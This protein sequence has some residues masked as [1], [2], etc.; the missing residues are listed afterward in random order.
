MSSL[1]DYSGTPAV[2]VFTLHDLMH[3]LTLR[4]MNNA[5]PRAQMLI[6]RAIQDTIRQLPALHDWNYYKRQ[7]RFTSTAGF[8][9]E[10][11]YDHDGATPRLLTITDEDNIWPTD[12]SYGEIWYGGRPYR[13]YRR[14][15]STQVMLEEA[16]S[17]STD[18]EGSVRFERRAYQFSREITKVHHM[19]NLTTNRWIEFMPT[20]E[21]QARSHARWGYGLT[22]HFTFQNHGGL[23]GSTEIILLPSS[24]RAETYEVTATINPHIP[25]IDLVSGTTAVVT[26]GSAT[27][28][29][30]GAA[31][32]DKLIGSIFRLGRT[33]TA[34]SNDNYQDYEFQAFVTAVTSTT[35]TLSE[36]SPVA[37][38]GR[39]Y[40]I[41]SPVDIDA[42]VMLEFTE[43]MAF[44][45]YC[46]NHDHKSYQQA[47]AIALQ[48]LRIARSRNNK[49]SL[50]SRLWEAGSWWGRWYGGFYTYGTIC[51][52]C[53]ADPCTCV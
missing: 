14:I 20:A 40:T 11:S 15:N 45:K 29:C 17:P 38:S 8:T 51:D 49:V 53:G 43:D 26:S 6:Q 27:V 52:V 31:F 36:V 44:A 47:Y 39:G 33:A 12:A 3:R 9:A 25:K 34:P 46:Q 32:T 23:F 22:T 37:A 19:Q 42:S 35:L 41:S 18:F 50:N 48:S 5:S 28:T 10:V 21:F 16:F 1:R 4:T 13:I 2:E 30:S 7:S 24:T